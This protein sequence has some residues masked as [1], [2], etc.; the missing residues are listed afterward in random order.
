MTEVAAIIL[1]AGLSHRMGAQNK[2]LLPIGETPMIRN[3][4]MQYRAAIDGPITVVTGHDQATVAAKVQDIANIN[5]VFNPDYETGQQTSV[6]VGLLNTPLA[7]VTLIGLG[8]QPLLRSTD[9]VA[10][11]DAHRSEGPGKISIPAQGDTRGNPIVVPRDL[12]PHLTADPNKPGCMRFTR[13]NPDL[14]QRHTLQAAGFYTDIDTP[15]A[16]ALF[17]KER[18]LAR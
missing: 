13:D 14:V 3:V 9:I 5:C 6:G 17:C 1:A 11:L 18:N 12:R 2:L 4:V 10:L 16:Y 7:D 8:D 15:D